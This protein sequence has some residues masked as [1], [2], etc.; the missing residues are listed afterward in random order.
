MRYST[1]HTVVLVRDLPEHGF[2]AGDLGAIVEVYPPDGLEVEFVTAL[3]RTG[4][5]ATLKISDVRPIADADC[6]N[7]GSHARPTGF[8]GEDTKVIGAK[9]S[10]RGVGQ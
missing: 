1:L 5:L 10:E 3:G 2:R 6:V 8:V 9:I 4:A 7:A